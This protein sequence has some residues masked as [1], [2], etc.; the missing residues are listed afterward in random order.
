VEKANYEYNA[1]DGRLT[2]P[3]SALASVNVSINAGAGVFSVTLGR[4]FG[5]SVSFGES[6]FCEGG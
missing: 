5:M 1:N 6:R 2:N 4:A 3:T